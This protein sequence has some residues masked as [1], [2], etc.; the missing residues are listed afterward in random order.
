[1]GLQ[2]GSGDQTRASHFVEEKK[3][4]EGLRGGG[5][6]GGRK[7]GEE[8]GGEGD[9]DGRRVC[10]CEGGWVAGGGKQFQWFPQPGTVQDVDGCTG[11]ELQRVYLALC[12]F[13][14]WEKRARERERVKR[15]RREEEEGVCFLSEQLDEGGCSEQIISFRWTKKSFFHICKHLL[16]ELPVPSINRIYEHTNLNVGEVICFVEAGW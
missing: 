11:E 16:S 1:M 7:G 10:V 3:K 8:E 9:E 6:G 2:I 5:V 12:L 4:K 13:L 15:T 14:Y